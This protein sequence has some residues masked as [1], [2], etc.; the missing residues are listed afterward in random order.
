LFDRLQDMQGSWEEEEDVL[1]AEEQQLVQQLGSSQIMP[2]DF[3]R[4]EM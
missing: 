2:D 4:S 3:S 1:S